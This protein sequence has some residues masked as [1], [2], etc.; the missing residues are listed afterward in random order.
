MLKRPAIPVAHEKEEEERFHGIA[1]AHV[2]R[3]TAVEKPSSID[4]RE[5]H[6]PLKM[7][8]DRFLQEAGNLLEGSSLYSKIEIDADCFPGSLA[9]K[10]V[11]VEN[12]LHLFIL[13]GPFLAPRP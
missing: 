10:G 3:D 13:L 9:A 5:F 12:T 1:E 7:K 8:R 11:A 4:L 2:P 6:H